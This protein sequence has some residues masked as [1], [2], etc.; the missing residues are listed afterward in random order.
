MKKC[1]SL[2]PAAD[3]LSPWHRHLTRPEVD[4]DADRVFRMQEPEPEP[5]PR[6]SWAGRYSLPPCAP[7][8]SCDPASGA[9]RL[10]AAWRLLIG[11][12]GPSADPD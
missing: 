9:P 7:A 3:D 5:V 12:C 8:P 1:P 2:G 10:A 4:G 6:R 11:W